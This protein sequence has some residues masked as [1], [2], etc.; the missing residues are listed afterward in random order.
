MNK[1]GEHMT[2]DDE[3]LKETVE[4]G[5]FAQFQEVAVEIDAFTDLG[6]NV[7]INNEY[8]GLVYQN[9]MYDEYHVGQ[10]LKAFI[11]CVR[12][13]GKIDVS[14]QPNQA[15]NVYSTADKLL[16]HLQAAGGESRFN[17]QT[18]PEEIREEFHVSKKVFK[19]A[20]SRLYKQRKIEMTNNGIKLVD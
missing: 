16:E 13:D 4:P 6:M 5:V 2:T 3:Y 20:V 19:Q 14:L 17:N 11:K 10:T 15:A 12:E 7:A 8:V 18:S 9:E 1:Y